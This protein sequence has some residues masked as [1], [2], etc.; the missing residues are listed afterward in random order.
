MAVDP[1]QFKDQLLAEKESLE[2]DL[3]RLGRRNPANP[4]DWETAPLAEGETEFHDET[5]DRLEELEERQAVE[6]ELERRLESVIDALERIADGT[7]GQCAIC[8]QAIEERRLEANPAARTCVAH[9][10]E[11]AA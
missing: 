9:R 3:A 10:D 2:S 1:N 11:E 6:T 8:G 7:Y 4:Q 5:A